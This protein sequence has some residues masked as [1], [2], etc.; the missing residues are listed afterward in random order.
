MAQR[1][2][3]VAVQAVALDLAIRVGQ[4]QVTSATTSHAPVQFDNSAARG[5]RCWPTIAPLSLSSLPAGERSHQLSQPGS[6]KACRLTRRECAEHQCADDERE[7]R[8]RL[9][10]R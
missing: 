6:R 3:S 7:Y 8:A 9:L 4:A 1:Y 5:L 10:R 2:V